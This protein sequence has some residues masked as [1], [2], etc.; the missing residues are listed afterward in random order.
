[1]KILCFTPLP[2]GDGSGWWGRDLG[3][4][5]RAF[6][7][8]GHD[9][10]L[11]CY[12]TT[13]S[14][15]PFDR[16]VQLISQFQAR[17]KDWWIQ[18]S[19][20]LIVLGLWTQS[21]YNP[22][23][24]AALSSNA[25]VI[26][27][28]DG[29]GFRLPSCDHQQF[30][31]N[32]I[33]A[34]IDARPNWPISIAAVVGGCKAGLFE[35]FAPY[36]ESRLAATLAMIPLFLS[37]TPLST[38]SLQSLATRIKS[39]PSRFQHVPHPIDENVFCYA[40]QS[41]KNTV[42]AVGRWG[43]WQKDWPLTRKA[44]EI[45][46]DRNPDY[47]AVIFG[48]GLPKGSIGER[49]FSRG[50]C[51]QEEISRSLR[52]AKILFFASRYES[53]LLAGGEALCSGCTVIGPNNIPSASYFSELFD[54]PTPPERTAAALASGLETEAHAWSQCKRDPRKISEAARHQIGSLIVAQKI[55]ALTSELN[56]IAQGKS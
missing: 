47:E 38:E 45:F 5:V 24:T 25:R 16:P 48:S 10:Q 56:P 35:I 40:G 7:Q 34:Q 37:E 41:K 53:F 12:P 39:N 52:E 14:K 43:S 18:Q 9:A 26:E 15:D 22:I 49:L 8:L 55:L 29:D 6:R 19:P 20:D 50:I 13:H 36:F 54:G 21:K 30:W 23:R 27:R 11:V 28:C 46:L 33:S 42:I 2:Y 4:T 3:L 17:S 44:L 1:M 31:K 51:P 32:T